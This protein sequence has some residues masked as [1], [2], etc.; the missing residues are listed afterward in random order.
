M[1]MILVKIFA[2]ALALSEVT[3]QSQ[4]VKTHFDPVQDRAEVV[5]ILRDGCAH[6]RQAFDIESINLDD[7]IATALNDPK[8]V[9]GDIK[10]FHGINFADLNT[11]YHQFCKNENVAS[12]VVDLG[13]VIEFFN[14]AAAD[15][16]DP[17]RLKGRKLPSMSVVLDGKGGTFASVFEPRNRR[18][19]VSL[20]KIPDSVQKAFIAAEDRRFFQHHGVDERGIIR[21]FIGNLA[22]PGRPQG[23]STITQQVVKNLLV[24]DDVTYERKIREM[25][26]ASRVESTLSKPEILELYLNSAYLGRGAWGVEMAARSYFGKSAKDLTIAEGAMLAGLLKGPSFFNPDRHPERAKERLAY[27][28]SRMKEDGV[29]SAE[30]KDRALAAPPKL[31]AFEQRRRDSGLHFI[32][33]LGREAK[34]DGVASL[35]A[36]PYTVHSTINAALQREAETALQEGLARYELSSGRAQFRGPE[37]NIGDA[38]QKLS[39]TAGATA[40]TTGGLPTWQQALQALRLPLSD[41]HWEPA[42]ILDKGGK[43]GDGAM[44]VGIRDGRV[45]P[46]NAANWQAKRNLGLYDVVYVRVIDTRTVAKPKNAGGAPGTVAVGGR[47]ELRVRPTVQGAALVLE[48]KTGRILAMAGSF[49]YGLSQLNRTSQTQRQPGSAMKPLTYLT[50]LQAG[51]QPNTL[52]SDDAITLS[53]IGSGAGTG[54]IAR[55][56]GSA[57]REEYYWSPRNADGGV[58]G[59]FTMRRGLENSVNVVTA[60]LLDGG[61]S[62]DPERSLDE[63]C[64]T[65]VAA[66]IYTD[67]VRYYPFVLGAQPVRMI[68]LAAFYAAVANEGALPKPHAIDSIEADGHTVFQYPNA[69]LP[70]IG[71]ADRTSFYQLKTMLQ[72]VVAR[73]TARAIGGLS[74]Y[75]AGKT[76]TTEDAVDGWFVGFTNDITIAVWVGYDN[77]DG[78]R[79]SLGT[80]AT[81]AR[82]ALPIFEP[83]L[84]AV[85]AQ[86]IAPKTPLSGPSPEAKRHLVDL[87][88]DYVSG[89]RIGGNQYGG[90]YSG[91]GFIEHFRVEADGK[92]NETQY[93]LVSHQDVDSPRYGEGESGSEQGWGAWGWGSRGRGTTYYPGAQQGYQPAPQRPVARAP[94]QFPWSNWDD[95]RGFFG[96]RPY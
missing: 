77:G 27:V 74:P 67:C 32:D 11:A 43:R 34:A 26:V 12:P 76:G 18:V 63:V 9:A 7:L 68:D 79:R 60:H 31:L 23:G 24:G 51:L 20:A 13:Q 1:D 91:Q 29:I 61:I 55:E 82:V 15:L 66:K 85:W 64:A 57:L 90:Q 69:P 84:Q 78:K 95:R 46:L 53:P 40:A 45:L 28:L 21:A 59:L 89:S 48:N 10:A 80:N 47:A 16:P 25:I 38:I 72:G 70:F 14:N 50:A 17:A 36:E 30:E 33:F 4:A 93:Q 8:A 35:T 6:M 92:V 41:V 54:I 81:G 73:G 88:I 83:I 39:A 37:A 49:S 62:A 65:A 19:W 75:V 87:P 22:D 44:R 94:F 52:V 71:A 2:T 58:G 56:Y 86:G 5:Q 42:V 96:D 3:T